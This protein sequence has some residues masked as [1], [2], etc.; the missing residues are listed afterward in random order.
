MTNTVRNIRNWRIHN[1]VAH[2]VPVAEFSYCENPNLLS[3][4][5]I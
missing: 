5:T 4:D 2:I 1:I 3:A